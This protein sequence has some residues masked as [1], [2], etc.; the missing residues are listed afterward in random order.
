MKRCFDC[1]KVKQLSDFNRNAGRPDGLQTR[2]R[3]CQRIDSKTYYKAH[4][5]KM[6]QQILAARARRR[7]VLQKFVID[8]LVEHPCVDCGESDLLV[9]DFDHVR[10]IKVAGIADLI[11]R[12]RPLVMLKDEIAKC[13]VRCANCHRRKTL[14][15]R[16]NYRWLHAPLAQLDRAA[17]S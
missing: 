1:N 7:L 11:T 13:D 4:R 14:R 2:C 15:E 12:E 10:G 3:D 16:A 17:D 6:R 5:P 8:F 9:L